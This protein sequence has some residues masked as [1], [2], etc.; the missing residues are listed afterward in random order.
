MGRRLLMTAFGA[1]IPMAAR[2]TKGPHPTRC[3]RAAIRPDLPHTCRSQHPSGSAQSGRE[4]PSEP[5]TKRKIFTTL[6]S[7][8]T[9]SRRANSWLYFKRV[10]DAVPGRAGGAVVIATVDHTLMRGLEPHD[11]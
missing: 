8:F 7:A 1:L 3:S 5:G 4:L 6:M 9:S 10:F 11:R 2:D